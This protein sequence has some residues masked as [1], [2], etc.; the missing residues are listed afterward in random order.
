MSLLEEAVTCWLNRIKVWLISF[1]DAWHRC[2]WNPVPSSPLIAC[3]FDWSKFNIFDAEK[4][5]F[6]LKDTLDLRCNYG[7]SWGFQAH[8]IWIL[9]SKYLDWLE[10]GWW[11]G[12]NRH[13]ISCDIWSSQGWYHKESKI[14]GQRLNCF[15]VDAYLCCR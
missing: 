15:S 8:Y 7:T 13:W 5:T 11:F 14:Y 1:K 9:P 4:S 2:R 3:K 12:R 10:N 6:V